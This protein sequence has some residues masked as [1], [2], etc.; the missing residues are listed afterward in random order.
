VGFDNAL[1]KQDAQDDGINSFG[2][3]SDSYEG[4]VD[5]ATSNACITTQL[6]PVCDKGVLR[7]YRFEMCRVLSPMYPLQVN[8]RR[9]ASSANL[10]F[11]LD[12]DSTRTNTGI[13]IKRPVGY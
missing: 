1:H 5:F 7:K 3:E 11:D 4:L 6:P 2:V 13:S 8:G 12:L 10:K 9:L